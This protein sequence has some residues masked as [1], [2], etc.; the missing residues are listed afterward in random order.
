MSGRPAVVTLLRGL[1]FSNHLTDLH[2]VI[3][4]G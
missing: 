2:A 1:Y 4:V 3:C